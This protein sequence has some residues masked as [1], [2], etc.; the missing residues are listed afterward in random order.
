[1]VV[2]LLPL[3]PINDITVLLRQGSSQKITFDFMI[4]YILFAQQPACPAQRITIAHVWVLSCR[5]IIPSLQNTHLHNV[6]VV[7]VY[8]NDAAQFLLI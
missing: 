4:N 1:M 5:D 8:L 6:H 7:K 2:T 3:T